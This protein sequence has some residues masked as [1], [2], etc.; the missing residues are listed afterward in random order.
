MALSLTKL[1]NNALCASNAS[2]DAVVITH[3]TDTLEETAFFLDATV[4][5]DKPVVVVGAMRPSTAISADGPNNLLQAVTTAVAPEARERGTLIVMNDRICQVSGRLNLE[6]LYVADADGLHPQ[7][8]FCQ[9]ANSNTVDTFESPEPGF[10]GGL[11]SDKPFF[12]S[13][14]STPTFKRVYD[15]RNVSSLPPVEVLYG[16]Q[17]TDLGLLDAAVERGAKGFVIAGTGAGSLS[18]TGAVNVA[19]VVDKG[20]PVVRSSKINVGASALSFWSSFDK[21]S[22]LCPLTSWGAVQAS[23][24]P[25]PFTPTRLPRARST[26]S[27]RAA[28]FRSSLRSARAPRRSSRRLRS[29]CRAILHSTSRSTTRSTG[30]KGC[31]RQEGSSARLARRGPVR[32]KQGQEVDLLTLC[33][34]LKT[35]S[36]ASS[37]FT[38]RTRAQ[39]QHTESAS[40]STFSSAACGT[41]VRGETTPS[42]T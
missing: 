26:R 32:V 34:L 21:L 30:R 13:S 42:R 22:S 25:P 40:P 11:L 37:S 20:V 6:A 19:A 15:L 3:G 4:Q 27:R 31:A 12:Y 1:V 36:S 29:R 24:S 8:Y 35:R 18:G 9:K 41:T 2:Y 16:Y 17:G 7:A 39:K 14:A 10:I 33:T 28:S 38:R 23:P 5:C